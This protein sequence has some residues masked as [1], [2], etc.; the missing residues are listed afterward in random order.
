MFVFPV[1]FIKKKTPT[2]V[3][4]Q[5]PIYFIVF[6]KKYKCNFYVNFLVEMKKKKEINNI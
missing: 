1:F 4:L 2:D 6:K 3:I 5:H